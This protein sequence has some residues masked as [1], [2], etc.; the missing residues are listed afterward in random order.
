[1]TYTCWICLI[2]GMGL[3]T[4]VGHCVRQYW[5]STSHIGGKSRRCSKRRRVIANTDLGTTRKHL[6]CW[7]MSSISNLVGG[8][9]KLTSA[10]ATPRLLFHQPSVKCS[11]PKGKKSFIFDKFTIYDFRSEING[12]I[13]TSGIK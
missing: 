11:H 10:M 1:M 3:D 5:D 12:F 4:H 13:I 8:D 7:P 9:M 2:F 6:L